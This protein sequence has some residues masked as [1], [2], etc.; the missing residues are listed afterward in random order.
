MARKPIPKY[1]RQKTKSGDRAFV[2]LAGSRVYLGAYDS[3]ESREAY[4]RTLAEWEAAGRELT[5]AANEITVNELI[6]RFWTYAEAYYR[7]ADGSPTDE[8]NNFRQALRPL[9]SIYGSIKVCEFRAKGLK[10]VREEM[11]RKGWCRTNIN[12][13]VGRLKR[14]FR[15]GVEN[16]IVPAEVYQSV[17]AVGGLRW[18]RSE[19]RESDPV[20]PV[21]DSVVAATLECLTPTLQAMVKAQRLTGMR[22]GELCQ[23]RAC[24]LDVT[25]SV[26]TYKPA[27]HKTQHYGRDRIVFIGP[28]AQ[29]ILRPFLNRDLQ[30]RLFSPAQSEA[31]RRETMRKVRC[32]PMSCGNTPGSNRKQRPRR[33]AGESY[34]TTSYGRAITYACDAAFPVPSGLTVEDVKAWRKSHRWSPNRLRHNFATDVRRGH[35]LESA[36]ILLGHSKADVTQVYAERDTQR[37]VAVARKI[38]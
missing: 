8:Q 17:C 14:L 18:G 37:A 7:R 30:S 21:A 27:T 2:E 22:P 9:A 16:D 38:G 10:I 4:A 3:P 13:M 11:V 34:T 1:R 24:D 26:W 33:P 31:E 32:T 15:W 20:K 25:T 12:K 36:Q 19:A 35:G 23:M 28:L 5:A 29:E 6:A